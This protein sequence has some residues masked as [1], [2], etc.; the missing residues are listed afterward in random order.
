MKAKLQIHEEK[1]QQVTAGDEAEEEGGLAA[2]LQSYAV[3]PVNNKG[4]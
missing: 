1:P 2:L 3:D 4:E